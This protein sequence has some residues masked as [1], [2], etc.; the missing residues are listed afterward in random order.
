MSDK[1]NNIDMDRYFEDPEYR[2]KVMGSKKSDGNSEASPR[3]PL[4]NKKIILYSGLGVLILIAVF[5]DCA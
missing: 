2:K 4:L 5:V 3:K 1:D